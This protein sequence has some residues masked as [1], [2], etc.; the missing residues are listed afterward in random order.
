M[1]GPPLRADSSYSFQFFFGLAG[2]D[3]W[4]SGV[5]CVLLGVVLL[6]RG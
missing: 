3:E 4:R 5:L 6:L 2:M 1:F